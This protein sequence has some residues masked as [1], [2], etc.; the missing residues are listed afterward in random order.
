MS[1]ILVTDGNYP[2]TLGI[3]RSLSKL[4]HEVDCIG[5]KFCLSSF[6]KYLR[7][8]IYQKTYLMMR[9]LINFWIS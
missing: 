6:S 7:K 8:F 3:I 4:G 5:N 2:H 1:K 9:I